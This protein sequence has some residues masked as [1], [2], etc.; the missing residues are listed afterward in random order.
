MERAGFGVINFPCK[1]DRYLLKLMFP[2]L[3]AVLLIALAALLAE[4]MLRLFDLMITY[5]SEVTPVLR[6]VGSLVPHYLGLALPVAFCIAVLS[7]MRHLSQTSEAVAM[8]SAGWSLR[9]IGLPFLLC[10]VLFCLLSQMLFGIVQPASRY[11]YQTIRHELINAGWNGRIEEG[12][13]FK[14]KDGFLV[15]TAGI[16]DTGRIL[17]EVFVLR[18]GKDG[19][20]VMTAKGGVLVPDV[21]NNHVRL[22]LNNGR[23]L[24]PDGKFFDFEKTNVKHEFELPE[25]FRSRGTSARELTTL[26]LWHAMSH[27][28]QSADPQFAAEFHNRLIRSVSLIG[29][30]MMAVPLGMAN[31]RSPGWMP[32][33]VAVAVLAI[34]DNAIKFVDGLAQTERIDPAL[35]MWGLAF[36]FNAAGL[37]LFLTT[38]SASWGPL[39]TLRRFVRRLVD[40]LIPRKARE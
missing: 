10:G 23:L 40:G 6:M 21:E 11:A 3:V 13:F 16:D 22:Q 37:W 17:D 4:R 34:F 2:R 30:A 5:G 20:T 27:E 12:S 38:S 15:S 24:L 8:G 29:I 33:A 36:I 32:L 18:E 31:A 19:T 39:A 1:I 14:V 26:E 35:G 25:P 9:R 28:T 7:A